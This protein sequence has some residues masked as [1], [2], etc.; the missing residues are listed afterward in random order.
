V[1][2]DLDVALGRVFRQDPLQAVFGV[3]FVLDFRS[4]RNRGE[5]AVVVV[6]KADREGFRAVVFFDRRILVEKI[7]RVCGRQDLEGV[8]PFDGP[9]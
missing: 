6:G 3:V 4:V 9:G 8:E 1:E 2:L 5:V 7:G